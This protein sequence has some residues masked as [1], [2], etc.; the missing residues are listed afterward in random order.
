MQVIRN[1]GGGRLGLAAGLALGAAGLLAAWGYSVDDALISARVAA[2]L[3][4]G[5]G[6]RFNPHGEVVDA[7]TPLGY[8]YL[9]RLSLA[10]QTLDVFQ[11]ARWAGAAA[12]LLTC[13]RLGWL[14]AQRFGSA[15]LGWFAVLAINPCGAAWATSGM[16][17]PWIAGLMLLGLGRYREET[18][19]QPPRGA[20]VAWRV[21]GP[22]C[23]GSA[24]AL[25]PELLPCC[26]VLCVGWALRERGLRRA[27]PLL[28]GALPTLLVVTLRLRYFG[29]GM[30]LSALAKPSDLAS[31]ARYAVGGWLLSGPILATAPIYV[32]SAWRRLSARARVGLLALS[33]HAA[34]LALAGGDWMALFRLY[35]P[36]LPLVVLVAAELAAPPAPGLSLVDSQGLRP[37]RPW[38]RW[39]RG[40]L[41]LAG[42]A[43]L[44]AELG[45][46]ARHVVRDRLALIAAARPHLEG[47][48]VASVDVGWVG[49]AGADTVIDL[50]GVTDPQVA[51]LAGGHTSKR[52]DPNFLERHQAN[53]LV[54]LCAEQPAP[55]SATEL[56][57]VRRVETKILKEAEVLG[58]TSKVILPVGGSGLNYCVYH[59]SNPS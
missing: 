15:A 55:A 59:L 39:L 33:A 45:L 26:G 1:L 3:N 31:G 42:A 21:V 46:P 34:A 37:P 24:A 47:Q 20:G 41:G 54:L 50:A 29:L 36:V 30:P 58:V 25:R 35:V 2:N 48:R 12:W 51:A 17:T 4:G 49:G 28:L 16:E 22:V 10:T 18:N 7:V 6:Y 52:L 23:L 56:L 53:R 38:S 8:A 43:L 44:W 40:A 11:W 27:L 9:L 19:N 14:T 5:F 13:A 32:V 57:P